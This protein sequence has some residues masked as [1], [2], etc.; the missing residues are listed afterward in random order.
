MHLGPPRE[1]H[2]LS[3]CLR[4]QEAALVSLHCLE[5]V[6]NYMWQPL[7]HSAVEPLEEGALHSTN[8]GNNGAFKKRVACIGHQ[9]GNYKS[10]ESGR[11][12]SDF[13]LRLE[14]LML[15]R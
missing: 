14:G 2:K 11:K 6:Q 12:Q 3:W 10:Q 8:S 4:I 15:L 7:P 13:A 5:D 9:L 1:R